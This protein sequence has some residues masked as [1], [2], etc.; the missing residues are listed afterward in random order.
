MTEETISRVLHD[1]KIISKIRENDKVCTDDGYLNLE[2]STIL[3]SFQRWARNENRIKGIASITNIINDAFVMSENHIR[4]IELYDNSNGRDVKLSKLK[5][6]HTVKEIRSCISDCLMGLKHLKITYHKDRSIRAKIDVLEKNVIYG[7]SQLD[8]SL[9]ELTI[10]NDIKA[11]E[12]FLLP[13]GDRISEIVE[14]N[15]DECA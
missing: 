12:I 7:L 1:L 6:F 3:C 8:H 2:K 15:I 11:P 14:V 5:A 13:P 4:K 10:N 9:N